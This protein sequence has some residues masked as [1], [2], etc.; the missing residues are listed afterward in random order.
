MSEIIVNM[1]GYRR[2]RMNLDLIDPAQEDSATEVWKATFCDEESGDCQVVYYEMSD[3]YEIWDLIDQA[4]Q[5]YRQ[6]FNL[7]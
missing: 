6:E 1:E 7:E 4:I 2:F 3:D 5:T